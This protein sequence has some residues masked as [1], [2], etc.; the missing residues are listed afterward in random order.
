MR[1][2]AFAAVATAVVATA[3]GGS[4]G[5]M[6]RGGASLV[7]HPRVVLDQATLSTLRQRAKA[8]TSAWQALKARCDLYLTGHVEWPDG[9]DYPDDGS[10]GE[11][12]QGDG[13][14]P[15]LVNVALCYQTEL[16]IDA[17]KAAA[18]GA[19]GADVLYHMSAPTGAHAP[20]PLRDSGYGIRFYGLGMAIGYDWLYPALDSSLRTRVYTA[21]NTWIS[22]YQSGGF[23]RSFPQGNYF[24]GYY[25][26]EGVAA[27]ATEGDNPSAPTQWSDWLNRVHEQMVRPYYAANLS[28]GG[29]PEG[30]NYGPL[31]TMNMSS[32]PV[33]AAKTAKGIDLLADP[34]G[35][36]A[37]PLNAPRY[38]LYFTWPNLL[39]MDDSDAVYDA[40]NPTPTH[41]WFVTE[42][43]GLLERFGSPFAPAFHS[44]ARAIRAVQPGG[45]LGPDWDL[46]ENFL[47]W[48]PS[49]PEQSYTTLPLSYYARGIENVAM[50]SS[51]N[52]NAVWGAF[53]G[54]PYV[55]YT[56]NGE[57]Y[58][59]KG[60]LAIV[61]GGRPLLVNAPG[62]LLRNTPGTSDGSQYYNLVYD[63][64]FG[65]P[66]NGNR[67]LFNVFYTDPKPWGQGGYLRSDGNAAS[68]TRFEDGGSYVAVR[69][70]HLEGNYPRNGG[71]PRSI[72]SWTR[73]VVYLRPEIF[74]VYDRTSVT[75]A[76]IAQWMSFHLGRQ[77]AAGAA[78]AAGV[79][80]FDVGS[81][82]AYAGTVETV[83]PQG[84]TATVTGVFGA[85]K[86]DRLAVRP[87][88]ASATNRW[89]TVFDAAASPSGAA[90]AS[91]LAPT[92][93]RGVL[94]TTSTKNFVVL[95][96]AGAAGTPV[97]GELTY[98]VPKAP[99]LHVITDLKPSTSYAIGVS[100]S[101]G[102]TTVDVKPGS[103]PTTSATG[104]LSFQT[105]TASVRPSSPRRSATRAG[106]R[107]ARAG[108]ARH[109]RRP[110]RTRPRG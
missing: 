110:P 81:G 45:E 22:A 9:N 90:L 96:G 20:D 11:G 36:Y 2:R 83:L 91:P 101:A 6:T 44:S 41:P 105:A 50:R 15:A 84:H 100:S 1:M 33:V 63:D 32:W 65:D 64:L 82:T 94:L 59:D 53:K 85:H 61:R 80:R 54:G 87:G 48:N 102:K 14:F 95:A 109:A 57:E 56:D 13:Y 74:V 107:S 47:F 78:P 103:G 35:P 18:Y 38:S 108:F 29:W 40:D 58:F 69:A 17:Q 19:K 27:L 73:D 68:I 67:T 60:S 25:A 26:A 34:K 66:P 99:T 75:N 24:A 39:T 104:V 98:T 46:W 77:A 52:T 72:T 106:S 28:G 10:I 7:P 71:E 76:S 3:A 21:L 31:G 16:G 12:Y 42:Q 30:W 92:G 5:A 70:S 62:A 79:H 23:E 86:I 49:A 93:M 89:L 51:W 43:A 37:Y 88:S 8:N 55:N 97:T 4:A